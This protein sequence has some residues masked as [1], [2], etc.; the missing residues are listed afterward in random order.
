MLVSW[1]TFLFRAT[2]VNMITAFPGN[3]KLSAST[4][5]SFASLLLQYIVQRA[6]GLP[7]RTVNTC[8]LLN[9]NVDL[10]V[11]L[12]SPQKTSHEREK[13]S[14]ERIA[15]GNERLLGPIA[16]R[17]EVETTQHRNSPPHVHVRSGLG[18]LGGKAKDRGNSV[19]S[20]A[21]RCGIRIEAVSER[22]SA[23][24]FPGFWF[25]A[26]DGAFQPATLCWTGLGAVRTV[27]PVRTAFRNVLIWESWIFLF[28][29]CFCF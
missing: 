15:V 28:C 21:D 22:P 29:F 8:W 25:V 14:G 4:P 3:G 19:A 27:S 16:A 2:A 18:D 17:L 6:T 5:S 7:S 12:L 26:S 20:F 9:D 1:R 11:G 13:L 23:P 24:H 10:L